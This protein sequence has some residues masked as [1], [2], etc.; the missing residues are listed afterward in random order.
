MPGLIDPTD[1]EEVEIFSRY[2]YRRGLSSSILV[3]P[4]CEETENGKIM[5]G[6]YGVGGADGY[7]FGDGYGCGAGFSSIGE[8][9]YGHGSA[10]GRGSGNGHGTGSGNGSGSG[11]GLGVNSDNR[12]SL[13][14]ENLEDP[15]YSCG[16]AKACGDGLGNGAG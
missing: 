15:N 11:Y 3:I 16:Y 2:L 10:F 7:G 6:T 14:I 13:D 4:A 5:T 8:S 9:N 12:M 1:I